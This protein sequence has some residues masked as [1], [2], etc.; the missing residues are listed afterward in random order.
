MHSKECQPEGCSEDVT[1]EQS[2]KKEGGILQVW[3]EGH[4]RTGRQQVQSP[5]PRACQV[6]SRPSRKAAGMAGAQQARKR[7]K[8][9]GT[10]GGQ[11]QTGEGLPQILV[12]LRLL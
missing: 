11:G 5:E 3:G 9:E 4:C 8:G 10:R 7:V 1:I 12:G 6:C 2:L